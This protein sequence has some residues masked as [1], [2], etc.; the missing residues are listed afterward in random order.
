MKRSRF[1]LA[2]IVMYAAVA[3]GSSLEEGFQT[4]PDSAKPRTFYFLMNGNVTKEG[5]T[6][7]LEAMKA[8]GLG[9]IHVFDVGC[10]LPVG[11][12]KWGSPEW[13]DMLRHLH[14][15]SKR[16]GMEL[17][18]HICSG[19]SA[20]GGPWNTPER[21]MKEIVWTETPFRG[22]GRFDETLP[23]TTDDNG[24]YEDIAV[25][26]YPMPTKG[27]SLSALRAKTGYERGLNLK[28]DSKAWPDE[29][30]V[31]KGA[32]VDLTGKMAS[33][34]RLV[35]D[36]P[37]GDWTILRVGHRC[38]GRE[39]V[40][41]TAGGA[42]PEVDKY[43]A[44]AVDFCFNAHVVKICEV[45]GI[46]P[47][48]EPAKSGTG[49]TTIHVDSYEAKRQNWTQ[50]LEKAFERRF[51]YSI[52]PYLPVF[53]GRVVG[54]AVE[55]ERVLE[56]FRRLLADLLA[57]NYMGRITKRCH[58]YG[59]LVSLEPYGWS[60]GDDLQYGQYADV[61][62]SEF[63]GTA[64]AA[65]HGFGGSQNA[66]H[67]ASLSHV[68][69]RRY[70]GAEAFTAG[71]PRFG[72]WLGTPFGMKSQGDQVYADG[73]NRIVYHR[74]THQPW[75]GNK[76]VPGFTMGRW[77]THLDRTQT[78]WRHVPAWFAYQSRCQW[79]LQEGRNVADALCWVGEEAPNDGKIASPLPSGW[80]Y[81]T[82]AT[83]VVE[84]LTV[85]DGRLVT[86]G[87]ADYAM[88]VLPAKDTMSVRLVA[89]I[90][91]LAA[92]GA[93]IVAPSRPTRAPG[94]A[95]P[96]RTAYA[97]LVAEAWA[98]GVIE[99][100][101][102][103]APA[104]L[105][106]A[107][108]FE[109]TREKV[110][111]NHR[112]GGEADWYFVACDNEFPI[113]FEVSLRETGRVPEIWN[114][115]TGERSAAPVWR[116]ENGR[117]VVALDFPPSGSMFVMLRSPVAEGTRHVVKADFDT[118]P[119][120]PDESHTLVIKR[121]LWGVFPES[122]VP[123]PGMQPSA[124]VDVTER[125]SSFIT[126]GVIDV[127]VGNKL[128]DVDVPGREKTALV[129]YEYDFVQHTARV[130]D[131][132]RFAVPEYGRPQ[133]PPDREWHGRRLL[134]WR[135]LSGVLTWSDGSKS[136]L[137][138]APRAPLV[139][140]GPWAVSFPE[141]VDA[142]A[143][144][145]FPVLSPWN[146]SSVPGIRY[147]SGTA[148]Y[149]KTI[150]LGDWRSSHD[151]GVRVMLDLGIVQ[152][153]AVVRVNGTAFPVLWKPPYRLDVTD[154]IPDGAESF[155]LEID[156]TNLWPNRLIGDDMLCKPDCEWKCVPKDGRLEYALKEIP[157]WVKAGKKSPSGRHTFTTWRHWSK[158]DDLLA[159]GLLGPV[160]LHFGEIVVEE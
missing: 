64:G 27:A 2:A 134:A 7:D 142:S 34:G 38:T 140:E 156:V 60:N 6:Y 99:C 133:P 28:R 61:P 125:L 62:F 66:R 121:A 16:L 138:A 155:D 85:K 24:F 95:A 76:Y 32:I 37:A 118:A 72:R 29:A 10:S 33:D 139:V 98:K 106:I 96:G 9:G 25:L 111:W 147:F 54:S 53:A 77:G 8:A 108:D 109:T 86:P 80:N 87:G 71:P 49:L 36:V 21:G 114:A 92:A 160:R 57:E 40:M 124:V 18:L 73:V 23:R 113:S 157:E 122:Q 158:E 101:A 145:E 63:W 51:G 154:A 84:E 123:G 103:D 15:E 150:A 4:P 102:K 3:A 78:W 130:W 97:A 68:W 153:F 144:V 107:K 143:S 56:D 135:P 31:K 81:D 12:I 46:R 127:R 74:F 79:M 151:G 104:K 70:T 39:N 90:G 82:C 11:P 132:G 91:E 110:S 30:L 75:P 136:V 48:D 65:P 137:R 5:I 149:R 159:S 152:N 14:S 44:E 141:G 94:A 58:E 120:E 52:I 93:R 67:A 47:G 55:S 100:A 88:L 115:E 126:N 59:L 22:P 26:A 105:G 17:G 69:G 83:R 146:E 117:T 42:G 50:G 19:W 129:T 20:F 43:S 35:W 148:T 116:I 1:C 41:P 131:R 128:F 13:F 89:R 119:R 112:R 45:L